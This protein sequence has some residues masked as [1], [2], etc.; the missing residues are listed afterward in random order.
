MKRRAPFHSIS[1]QS[2]SSSS[3]SLDIPAN[4]R[5][6]EMT[7]ALMNGT[8]SE[9]IEALKEFRRMSAIEENPFL[10]D[11]VD[12]GVI[13]RF[14]DL[15]SSSERIIQYEVAWILTN[16][17]SGPSEYVSM[18]LDSGV[19]PTL[20]KLATSSPG[21]N[22]SMQSI[23]CIGNITGDTNPS[24]KE[25]CYHL[26]VVGC[27][28][29]II[30][31]SRS[32]ETTRQAMW[33]LSNLLNVKESPGIDHIAASIA[34]IT[35][36]ILSGDREVFQYTMSAIEH[37]SAM[38]GCDAI[39]MVCNSHIPRNLRLIFD[40]FDR[41]NSFPNN[42]IQY[43]L[44]KILSNI[45]TGTNEQTGMI[46]TQ[47][48][49]GCMMK[50][51]VDGASHIRKEIAFCLSN[52]VCG[53]RSH[54]DIIIT[55]QFV[56]YIVSH[57]LSFDYSVKREC[58]WMM[59]NLLKYSKHTIE[60]IM[61][62]PE[63]AEVLCC[64]LGLKDVDVTLMSLDAIDSVLEHTT[65]NNPLLHSSIKQSIEMCGGMEEIENLQ[66]ADNDDIYQRPSQFSQ[67]TSIKPIK[68]SIR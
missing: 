16:I 27:L 32:I 9:M 52:V 8:H 34:A 3:E 65:D 21:Q 60:V 56:K 18:I 1:P 11:I 29:E 53:P 68:V 46:V 55:S 45:A 42:G 49:I 30:R 54:I 23:W 5:L 64:M 51:F 62:Y 47:P 2:S 58:M 38:S 63:S 44:C 41:E 57:I 28:V 67:P 59:C 19:L 50:M 40:R 66:L 35:N 20:M 48:I 4:L 61:M 10:Q 39:G 7:E 12:C 6:P 24:I 31:S 36:F 25:V 37:I 17:S 22:V 13:P 33:A 15:L 26:G 43:S 14:C